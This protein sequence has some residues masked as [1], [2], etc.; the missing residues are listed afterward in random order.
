MH[1]S[2]SQLVCDY[3]AEE[4]DALIAIACVYGVCSFL[5]QLVVEVNILYVIRVKLND[6]FF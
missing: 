2:H 6:L 3:L 1:K 5:E 4:E